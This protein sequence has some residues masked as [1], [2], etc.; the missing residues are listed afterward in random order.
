MKRIICILLAFLLL[1]P[2]IIFARADKYTTYTDKSELYAVINED[3][4]REF[5]GVSPKNIQAHHELRSEDDLDDTRNEVS[6]IQYTFDIDGEGGLPSVT[7]TTY[8]TL[9]SI[10]LSEDRLFYSGSSEQTAYINGRELIFYMLINYYPHY[11]RLLSVNISVCAAD[12]PAT[13]THFTIGEPFLSEDMIAAWTDYDH[14]DERGLYYPE[15]DN[16][17]ALAGSADAMFEGNFND[18]L[19]QK[20]EVS[21]NQSNDMMNTR[22][23]TNARILDEHF[24]LTGVSRTTVSE[25]HIT[26]RSDESMFPRVGN[27]ESF[28]DYI[29][30]KEV[31]RGDNAFRWY[32]ILPMFYYDLFDY[33]EENTKHRHIANY[34]DLHRTDTLILKADGS[35]DYDTVPFEL[36]YR[37]ES[38]FLT[39]GRFKVSS[40]VVYRT[41]YT[42]HGTDL[43]VCYITEGGTAETEWM[44]LYVR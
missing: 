16:T 5:F 23:Y 2:S 6:G 31:S 14:K 7:T 8:E 19:S 18:R 37:L 27:I 15:P 1:I 36:N 29:G 25:I 9:R 43:V 41:F 13:F 22:V 3:I 28:Y 38:P 21:Y 42:P 11:E 17:Y 32:Y 40:H 4:F 24:S 35:V 34:G 10:S 39:S 33:L 44:E 12:D 26:I 20:L 30:G